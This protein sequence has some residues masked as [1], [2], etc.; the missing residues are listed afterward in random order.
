[1]TYSRYGGRTI[2]VNDEE[3]YSD[4]FKK[5]KVNFIKQY[6]TGELKA[7]TADQ[8]MELRPIPHL[9]AEG[10]RY[11]KLA[12]QY[13]NDPTLWWVIA[14][15]NQAPT[16]AHVKV[17]DVVEVPTPLDTILRFYGV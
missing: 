9:W 15:Y 17:G 2:G 10:S 11:Y 16:E 7:P 5:R 6:F 14:W 13:Y 8:I 3:Q 1:M 4:L 12:A